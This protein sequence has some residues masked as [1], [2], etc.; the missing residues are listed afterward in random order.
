MSAAIIIAALTSFNQLLMTPP[1]Q[2]LFT[3]ANDVV[4]DIFKLLHVHL[5]AMTPTPPAAIAA[6]GTVATTQP[7]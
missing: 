6:A 5:V 4:V 2:Q 7:S 3:N 1:G